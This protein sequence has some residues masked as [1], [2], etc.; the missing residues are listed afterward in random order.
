MRKLKLYL[1]TSAWN[2]YFADDA[3]EKMEI[4]KEFFGQVFKG[5]YA[6]YTSRVALDEIERC[7]EPKRSDLFKLIEK[8][9]P[10]MLEV[11]DE[12]EELAVK[13]MEKGLVPERKEED[14]LHIAVATVTEMDAVVTWNY[15]HMI[16]LRKSELFHSTNLEEGYTKRIEIITPMGVGFDESR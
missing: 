3:P 10:T 9:E 14:A 15:R 16:G 4:T 8:S 11:G 5:V 13:Y 2:F 1:E 12:A 7:P 6:V